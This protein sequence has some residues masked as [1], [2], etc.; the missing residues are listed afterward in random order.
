MNALVER[1]TRNW[2]VPLLR[3]LVAVLFGL[4]AF[5]WPGITLTVLV[6]L[7]GAFVLVDGVFALV[8]SIRYR[9]RM[10]RWWL[11]LLEG[12][13]GIAIGVLTFLW[14]G[15][16]ALVLLALIAVWAFLTGIVEIVAAIEL[17]KAIEGEWLLALTGVLSIIF[18]GLLVIWPEAG[19]LTLV[20]LIGLYAVLFGGVLVALALQLRRLSTERRGSSAR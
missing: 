20:W 2:W 7:F 5:V 4:L 13:I 18:G 19:L 17:R 3:G 6:I 1:L 8:S 9:A 11:W 14:P 12:L 10:E 16:T 15:V